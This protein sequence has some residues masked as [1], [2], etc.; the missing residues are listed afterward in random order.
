MIPAAR[1]ED[2]E[3]I[4]TTVGTRML[5]SIKVIY[6]DTNMMKM[7]V[8]C[9]PFSFLSFISGILWLCIW[10]ALSYGPILGGSMENTI[11]DTLQSE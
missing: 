3:N 10:M 7:K 11:Q 2:E 4:S 1:Q 9:V 8:I 6:R 5:L